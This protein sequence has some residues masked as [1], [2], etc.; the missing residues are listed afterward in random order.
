MC[1]LRLL[2]S[3]A[4]TAAGFAAAMTLGAAGVQAA[5]TTALY[6]DMDGSGSIGSTD[7]TT[8]VTAYSN[9]LGSYFA[10][11]PGAYGQVAIGGAVFGGDQAQFFPLTDI[12][13]S[14]VLGNLMSAITG[15]DPG[16]GGIDTSA[17]AIGNAIGL[18][19]LALN[20]YQASLGAGT[21]LNLIVDVTTDGQ[22]N[23]GV[24]PASEATSLVGGGVLDQVNCLGIGAGADCSFVNG[25]GTNYG[26]VDFAHLE[27]ALDAKITQETI[28]EPATLLLFGAGLAGL[29]LIRRKLA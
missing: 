28:P 12:T 7:F 25:A 3:S 4:L 19:S 20:A 2:F 22:N 13:D 29:G 14:T 23:L 18:A 8:Q 1:K 6:L 24:D 10:A 9:A 15:L 11:N 5:P 17:T 27:A 21:N 26:S 16:R